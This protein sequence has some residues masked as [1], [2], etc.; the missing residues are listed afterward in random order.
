MA[1]RRHGLAMSNVDPHRAD[2]VVRLGH[3][4]QHQPEQNHHAMRLAWKVLSA[5]YL[6]V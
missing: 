3:E 4:P 6:H 5:C 1:G 2:A